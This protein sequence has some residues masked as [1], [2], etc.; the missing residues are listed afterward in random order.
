MSVKYIGM[1][2]VK[3]EKESMPT[4]SARKLHV[5]TPVYI[6]VLWSQIFIKYKLA[7][8]NIL[9]VVVSTHP[10]LLNARGPRPT[11]VYRV[12]DRLYPS[13]EEGGASD[14]IRPETPR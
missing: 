10:A 12:P 4:F 5:I 14:G 7:F 11:R 1:N 8:T 2:R 13:L 3:E 9:V 6:Q